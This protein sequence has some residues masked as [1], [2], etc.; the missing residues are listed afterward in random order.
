MMTPPM[1]VCSAL[2]L[3][4]VAALG[5]AENV[6][7]AI[8]N[9]GELSSVSRPVASGP[10]A[11][12]ARDQFGA[13]FCG[14]H[15]WASRHGAGRSKSPQRPVRAARQR[16]PFRSFHAGPNERCRAGPSER[17]VNGARNWPHKGGTLCRAGRSASG[18][19]LLEATPPART[20]PS[21]CARTHLPH[22]VG[23]RLLAHRHPSCLYCPSGSTTSSGTRTGPLQ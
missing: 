22:G 14:P 5:A 4:I 20:P 15:A 11:V 3:A 9:D 6:L 2:L 7:D 17:A 12:R 19:R 18:R 23:S 13:M 10:V 1:A 21:Q 8:R 16:R